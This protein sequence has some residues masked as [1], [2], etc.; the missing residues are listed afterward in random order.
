MAHVLDA[1]HASS[2]HF[3]NVNASRLYIN[4]EI[5]FNLTYFVSFKL[6]PV[7]NRLEFEHD[8]IE[9]CLFGERPNKQIDGHHPYIWFCRDGKLVYNCSCN[10]DMNDS[11][12]V[13]FYNV[14][15]VLANVTDFEDIPI[16][17]DDRYQL[18]D[19]Q[20]WNY[21]K[22]IS[23]VIER[24]HLGISEFLTFVFKRSLRY[25]MIDEFQTCSWFYWNGTLWKEDK[26]E[27]F[28]TQFLA[29][30]VSTWLLSVRSDFDD[31]EK[32]MIR[33]I[34]SLVNSFTHGTAGAQNVL[35]FMRAKFMDI[36]F[37]YHKHT[38]FIAAKNGLVNLKTGM[39]R[40]IKYDDCITAGELL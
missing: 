21:I 32:K 3:T 24:G 17:I 31:K 13:S 33:M 1:L 35:K 29:D 22:T 27:I 15:I 11:N 18:P 7:R 34:E 28:L 39:I 25:V 20:N 40:N 19:G 26:D 38:G 2:P 14:P 10:I 5:F 23:E 16:I 37:Q 4:F 30:K 6:V 9:K 8:A 36:D 12:A